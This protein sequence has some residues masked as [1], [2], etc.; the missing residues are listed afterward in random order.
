[1]GYTHY[2]TPS[3]DI[4][5]TKAVKAAEAIVEH[6]IREGIIDKE[7]A[8]VS[9]HSVEFNGIGEDGHED[10]IYKVGGEWSFC[11]TA[12]K[13]YD[14][15]V[16]SVLVIL[17]YFLKIELNSDGGMDSDE[18]GAVVDFLLRNDEPFSL[19]MNLCDSLLRV[20]E[21][22]SSIFKDFP[23]FPTKG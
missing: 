9:V 7:S 15:Y 3:K 4:L 16:C 17:R 6:G 19:E 13:P 18:W 10:F 21:G 8:K 12:R 1:M 2:W 14:L 22:Q 23:Q 11:K 5:P 20:W